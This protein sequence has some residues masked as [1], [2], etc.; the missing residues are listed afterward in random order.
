MPREKCELDGVV[1]SE[2]VFPLPLS[3][4]SINLQ[5]TKNAKCQQLSVQTSCMWQR[6]QDKHSA[7]ST[8]FPSE[9]IVSPP[10]PDLW[11]LPKCVILSSPG[12][13]PG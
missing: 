1:G 6:C 7:L 12:S 13:V 11:V 5:E 9:R 2:E 4:S 8:L 3:S 10:R